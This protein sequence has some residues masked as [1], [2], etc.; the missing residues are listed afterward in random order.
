MAAPGP[1]LQ[2]AWNE[3]PQRSS[4]G[5]HP[6]RGAAAGPEGSLQAGEPEGAQPVALV[7]PPPA[8]RPKKGTPQVQAGPAHSLTGPAAA[9]VPEQC[10]ALP[11]FTLPPNSSHMLGATCAPSAHGA[12]PFVV[13]TLTSGPPQQELPQ[14]PEA[15]QLQA[16]W[17]SLPFLRACFAMAMT[18]VAKMMP[19]DWQPWAAPHCPTCTCSQHQEHAS[20]GMAP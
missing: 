9:P 6:T 20:C 7:G 1:A 2:E 11:C 13:P 15:P 12:L 17:A 10:H 3:S 8:K 16:P 18:A 5:A 4:P 14:A 19:P